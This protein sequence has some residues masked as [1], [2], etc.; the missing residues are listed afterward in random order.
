MYNYW[1][2]IYRGRDWQI[3]FN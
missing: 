3:N 1:L 2:W